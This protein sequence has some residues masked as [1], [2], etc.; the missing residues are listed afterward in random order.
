V[1]IFE[2]V[3]G[4]NGNVTALV[5]APAVSI[6][7]TPGEHFYYARVTQEDG[8]MLWSAPIWVS[9]AAPSKAKRQL[10]RRM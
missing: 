7:P 4:R 8:N 9:Q 6:V 10:S 5:R 2:G 3:P 1:V